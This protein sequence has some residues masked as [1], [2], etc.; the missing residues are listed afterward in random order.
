MYVLDSTTVIYSAS[1][2]SAAARCE[3]A[4]MRTLDGRLGR[5]NRVL[6]REDAMLRR[7]AEL[8]DEHEL[9]M[10]ERL[11]ATRAVVEIARPAYGIDPLLAVEQ[12]ESALRAGAE[13]V[14]QA[15]FFDGRFLGYADFI[16]RD[17]TTSTYEVYDTKLA[18]TAKVTALLQLAA[19]SDQLLR[20]GIPVGD[21]VHVVLGDGRTSSHRLQDI[22]PVYRQRRARLELLIDELSLIHI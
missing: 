18:R 10:L 12:S 3:W 8:G 16:I 7:T 20:E 21:L 14:Y 6:E 4:L 15:A 13:V 1:D 19:Y 17:P 9:R 5:I 2:L 11:R 22:L